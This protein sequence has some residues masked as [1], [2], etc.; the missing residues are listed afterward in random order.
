MLA[1]TEKMSIIVEVGICL[2][3]YTRTAYSAS[4]S[5]SSSVVGTG[6]SSLMPTAGMCSRCV[7][8]IHV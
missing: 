2:A 8:A 7:A 6:T 1:T 4:I 5:Y 3:S